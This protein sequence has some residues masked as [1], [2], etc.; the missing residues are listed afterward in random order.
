MTLALSS[1]WYIGWVVG[2]AVVLVAAVLLLAIIALGRRIARQ[3]QDITQAL[4]GARA[5]TDALYDVARTNHA[6]DRTARGL[7]T[8]RTGK[9]E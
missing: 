6:L 4:D 8:V 9:P 1:G 7:R 5:N 3:A 2:V